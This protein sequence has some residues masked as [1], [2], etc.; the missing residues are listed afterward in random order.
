MFGAILKAANSSFQK[1]ITFCRSIYV[2]KVM[3]LLAFIFEQPSY[4]C[5]PFFLKITIFV[6][7]IYI[8]YTCLSV[9]NKLVLC[10]RYDLFL[11]LYA[12]HI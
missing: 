1:G 4:S 5:F 10:L 8:P 7:I 11:L 6:I 9:F 12:R 2:K 3:K